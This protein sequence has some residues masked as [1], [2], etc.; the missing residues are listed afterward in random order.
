M[1]ISR[2]LHTK[3]WKVNPFTPQNNMRRVLEAAANI[4]GG[5]IV[6]FPTETVYGLG[7]SALCPEAVEKIFLAKGRPGDNPLIVHIAYF[8]QA[9]FLV[10]EVPIKA[11]VL[12]RRFWPGP[13]TLVMPKSP[14]VPEA[15]TAG[16]DTVAV[17][18][19]DHPVARELIRLSRCSI[20]APS[21]NISG[22]PSPTT[23]RHVLRDLYGKID[24]V[25][26]GGPCEVG[27]ESTVVDVT[28]RVPVLLRPGGISKE[29][30][31]ET[32]GEILVDPNIKEPN[33]DVPPR[34]PGMKYTHYAPSG[35][36]FLVEGEPEKAA[37]WIR[38][39][40]LVNREKGRRT[41]VLCSRETAHFYNGCVGSNGFVEVLGSK[42]ELESVARHLY[43]AL[44]R[45]DLENIENIYLETYSAQGIGL[46]VMNRMYKASGSN[47]VRV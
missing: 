25:L 43:S 7:G 35:K 14:A 12:A 32:V 44:R 37:A 28:S 16:L 42:S 39:E 2:R 18:M 6:A 10:R 41:A 40:C 38:R 30:L 24:G 15:V 46:A 34:S 23:A 26:D 21:A 27:V 19:P 22:K 8:W 11:K 13:L 36:V 3:Y 29:Q 9:P 1:K 31:E 45:C 4:A 20:A 47:I 17:R 33:G 5:G